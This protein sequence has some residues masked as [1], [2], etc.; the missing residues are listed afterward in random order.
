MP[1][2]YLTRAGSDFSGFSGFL[3]WHRGLGRSGVRMCSRP[4]LTVSWVTLNT[5]ERI[6]LFD[7]DTLDELPGDW[8]GSR[9][10]FNLWALS[11]LP[12]FTTFYHYLPP[13][14]TN[15]GFDT[16]SDTW[17]PGGLLLVPMVFDAMV[18]SNL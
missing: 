8:S 1:S 13:R 2:G 16:K 5:N 4:R 12:L 7:L 14:D 3:G 18:D 9:V 11:F 10:G 15:D 6:Y 17:R